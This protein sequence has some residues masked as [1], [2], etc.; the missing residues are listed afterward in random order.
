MKI[1]SP[2][3]HRQHIVAAATVAAMLLLLLLMLISYDQSANVD[4]IPRIW[5]QAVQRQDSAA[6]LPWQ[7][8]AQRLQLEYWW[9]DESLRGWGLYSKL[10]LAHIVE[11]SHGLN[12]FR[13]LAFLSFTPDF[14]FYFMINFVGSVFSSDFSTS[15]LIERQCRSTFG[16]RLSAATPRS[17]RFAVAVAVFFC[18]R[19]LCRSLV[20]WLSVRCCR[21]RRRCRSSV[22]VIVAISWWL[23]QCSHS[24]SRV[25]LLSFISPTAR[26]LARPCSD[27]SLLKLF[28]AD[29]S[30]IS[31]VT[32][33]LSP[34]LVPPLATGL[35]RLAVVLISNRL[36]SY[37]IYL[38][39]VLGQ[40]SYYTKV[41]LEIWGTA[42]FK[43][44]LF[45]MGKPFYRY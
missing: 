17:Q 18:H 5:C 13:A 20:S 12:A 43:R 42:E 1:R 35:S 40:F 33:Y 32:G 10:T 38:L 6:A 9:G 15:S 2:A 34:A 29:L 25:L 16:S 44:P 4:G 8:E 31:S 27:A 26:S 7:P 37:F 39:S 19:P 45:D 21:R 14:T 3:I 28:F 36:C 22:S 11:L 24:V 30:A 23:S 41:Q